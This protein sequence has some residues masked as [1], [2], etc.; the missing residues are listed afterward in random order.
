MSYNTEQANTFYTEFYAYL[1]THGQLLSA[2]KW[3][4]CEAFIGR[5]AALLDEGRQT[6]DQANDNMHCYLMLV[7]I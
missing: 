1:Q 5:E 2:G 7:G 3:L 4:N 6:L